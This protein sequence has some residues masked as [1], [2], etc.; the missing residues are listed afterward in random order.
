MSKKRRWL[1]PSAGEVG[2]PAP[3]VAPEPDATIDPVPPVTASSSEAET[4]PEDLGHPEAPE[5]PVPTARFEPP[6]AP[7]VHAS[8]Q[9]TQAKPEWQ[10]TGWYRWGRWVVFVLALLS[11]A[12]YGAASEYSNFADSDPYTGAF[13]GLLT[14]VM[15]MALLAG[16]VWLVVCGFL[17]RDGWSYR[18][19]FWSPGVLWVVFV[20]L[21]LR[22]VGDSAREAEQSATSGDA[23]VQQADADISAA[24]DPVGKKLAGKS[25]QLSSSDQA[26]LDEWT[27]VGS[28]F[29]TMI[30]R[31]LRDYNNQNITAAA[32]LAST[33]RRLR[34]AD[35]AATLLRSR[36]ASVQDAAIKS[37]FAK[38]DR[39][40]ANTLSAF[41]RLLGAVESGTREDEFRAQ[42]LVNRRL[43]QYRK[44]NRHIFDLARPYYTAEELKQFRERAQQAASEI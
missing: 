33:Q 3:E 21:F 23:L 16:L 34:R 37:Q 27:P 4:E 25:D 7:D 28:R 2:P 30:S 38:L 41:R 18:R 29:G 1:G 22:P 19:I 8:A 43:R 6:A 36:T 12:A 13:G 14:A 10:Q 44:A 39:V 15:I 11:S 32:W 17:S 40:R 31:V 9:Q 26:L 20:V 42:D 5:P 24:S 35:K